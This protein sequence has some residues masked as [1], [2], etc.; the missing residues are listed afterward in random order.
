MIEWLSFIA[1]HGWL[2]YVKEHPTQFIV[3][4]DNTRYDWM[5]DDIAKL[6]NVRLISANIDTFELID[7]SKA[8]ATL[9]GT[10]G[11][12]SV[13]RGKPVLCFGYAWY[14]GCEGVLSIQSLKQLELYVDQIKNGYKPALE[15]V[16]K[17]IQALEEIGI[18]G[19]VDPYY[20]KDFDYEKNVRNLKE[21]VAGFE[22]QN[23]S[24]R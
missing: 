11:F 12:E 19:Y 24:N 4:V 5:Y 15:K 13:I 1:P 16:R 2:I 7:N 18:K 23:S 10:I 8:I 21:A 14:R 17:F 22:V 9:T 20:A 6:H 3:K